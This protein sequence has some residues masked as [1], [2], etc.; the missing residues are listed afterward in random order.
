MRIRLLLFFTATFITLSLCAQSSAP[1]TWWNPAETPGIPPDG[2]GWP[3]DS[4]HFYSRLPPDAEHAV[5]KDVFDLSKQPSGITLHFT[6]NAPAIVVEYALRDQL[7]FPHMPATGVSGVDLYDSLGQRVV[8]TYQFGDTVRYRFAGLPGPAGTNPMGYSLYLPLYN[9]VKWLRIGVEQGYALTPYR[10]THSATVVVYGT[11]IAQ[12]ACASRP[13]LS[14]GNLLGRITGYDVI[15]LG[16]SGNG[17]LEPEVIGYLTRLDPT[18]YILDCLPNLTDRSP[19]E[20]YKKIVDAVDQVRRA[21][22]AT[23]I[24][25][26]EHAGFGNEQTNETNRNRCAAVNTALRKAIADL[27]RK[28]VKGLYLLEKRTIGLDSDSFVDQVHPNDAGM[29]RYARA[30]ARLIS[31]VVNR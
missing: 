15:N 10:K 18:V 11:S 21:H 20:V 22:P 25:L 2:I 7:Q 8:A 5:R 29:M 14:W 9:T 31:R 16:F 30:Y 3:Q 4:S 26:A 13:G 1:L 19:D 6:S 27:R 28:K 23:P 12:G 24:I 17:R